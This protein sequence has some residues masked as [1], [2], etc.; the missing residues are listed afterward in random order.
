MQST[1]VDTV[2]KINFVLALVECIVEIANIKSSLLSQ[3]LTSRDFVHVVKSPPASPT[4]PAPP[5]S[6]IVT[7]ANR[8]ED[9]FEN[10]DTFDIDRRAKPSFGFGFGPHMCIGQFVAKT[11]INCALNAVLDLMPN[12]RLDPD[13]P[14]PE[15]IG[16]QLR[17]PHQVHVIWD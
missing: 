15:I 17:G 11:E 2:K 3:S 16:A 4:A 6:R 5:S 7:S 14:A 9:A 13:K 10:A 1:H 8:D 12:I